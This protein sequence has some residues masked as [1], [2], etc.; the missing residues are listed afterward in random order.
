[1]CTTSDTGH[2]SVRDRAEEA[3]MLATHLSPGMTALSRYSGRQRAFQPDNT[4]L[5]TCN[6]I[7]PPPNDKP[8][9]YDC[10]IIA[11]FL[12]HHLRH[13]YL[14]WMEWRNWQ[15]GRK[16]YTHGKNES[17]LNPAVHPKATQWYSQNKQINNAKIMSIII[18]AFAYN[19][20]SNVI[21]M[22]VY[23]VGSRNIGARKAAERDTRR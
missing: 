11:P 23:V 22:S 20:L 16:T 17:H 8:E 10:L 7:P 2:P 9:K 18:Y 3:L 13:R 14:W 15:R 5:M 1:M 12:T 19:T 6:D 4:R 21:R